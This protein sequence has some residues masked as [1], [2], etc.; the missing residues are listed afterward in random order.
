MLKSE[1]QNMIMDIITR[2]Q[3][4]KVSDLKKEFGVSDE[5]IRRDLAEIEASGRIRCVHGGAILDSSSVTEFDFNIRAKQNQ[6]EKEA[7]CRE[8][9]KLV[10]E[11]ESIAILGSTTTMYMGDYL[12]RR[13]NLTVLTNS[14]YVANKIAINRTNEVIFAGGVLR[15]DEQRTM[16][17]LAE[18]VFDSFYVDKAFISVAGISP[19]GGITEYNELETR[20]TRRA[21][22]N[23]KQ[24]I[25]LADHSKFNFIA[26]RKIVDTAS[27]SD[28]VTDWRSDPAELEAYEKMGVTVHRASK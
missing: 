20:V 7:I 12:E 18:Q 6:I 4:V 23:A 5:T 15:F 24:V 11:K 13:N 17:D 21:M 26:F 8:A 1:R 3:Y 19:D 28:I 22:K 2:Q 27:I 14:I 25:L 10:N 9:A 16:G